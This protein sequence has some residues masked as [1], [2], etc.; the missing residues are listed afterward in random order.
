MGILL[1]IYI[2]NRK[3]GP[4]RSIDEAQLV[5]GQGIVGDRH[6]ANAG[7][8]SPA[9]HDPSHEITLVEIEQVTDFNAVYGLT[10]HPGDL[11]RNLVTEGIGLNELVGCEF[12][13]GCVVL[14]GIRLCEPC[15]YLAGLTH[16]DVRRGLRHRAGLRAGIVQGGVVRVR[17]RVCS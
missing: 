17:D 12:I 8:F 6:F 7:K 1:G 3:G 15:E 14:K 11:R 16:H 5:S 13:V 2:A 9:V 10:L 4:M